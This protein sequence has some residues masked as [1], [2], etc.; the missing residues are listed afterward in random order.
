MI[1]VSSPVL[2]I[3]FSIDEKAESRVPLEFIKTINLWMHHILLNQIHKRSWKIH[4]ATALF[5]GKTFTIL[6][7]PELLR[8]YVDKHYKLLPA[9]FLC[10]IFI[11]I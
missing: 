1:F 11:F 4:C 3:N 7:K 8:D 10:Y 5:S 6:P 2:A 9:G